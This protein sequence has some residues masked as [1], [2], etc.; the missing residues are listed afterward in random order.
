MTG[1]VLEKTAAGAKDRHEAMNPGPEVARI[2][3]AT[4]LTRG[5]EWLARIAANEPIHDPTPRIAV[6]GSQIRPERRV[7]Q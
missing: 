2:I 3:D 5:G 1:D 7:I 6:E 4:S